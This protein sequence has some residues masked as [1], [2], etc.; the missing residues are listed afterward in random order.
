L[1]I[2]QKKYLLLFLTKKVK[3]MKKSTSIIAIL[4]FALISFSACT[5]PSANETTE[6]G[7]NAAV[8]EAVAEEVE[9]VPV[10]ESALGNFKDLVGKWTIDA[11]TAGVQMDLSFGEDGSFTQKMGQINATGTWEVI[12]G[13]HIKI[14]TENTKGQTWL[15]T[16]LADKTVDICWNPDSPKPKTLPM[17]RVD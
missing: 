12:D 17:Q 11:A 8:E 15:V 9:E 14:V 6:A 2:C 13:E 10:Q 3:E 4:S 16:G 7:D 5:N 1:S